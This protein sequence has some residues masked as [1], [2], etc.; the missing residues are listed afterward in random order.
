VASTPTTDLIVVQIPAGPIQTNA[1]LIIDPRS[2][3]ALIIDAP[4]E[5]ADAIEAELAS[6]NAMPTTL[7]ITHGHWDHI[8][9]ADEISRR[10]DIPLVVH[11]SERQTLETP[12]S[13]PVQIQPAQVSRT[14]DEGDMISVGDHA[15]EVLV[16]PGHSPGQI[17]LYSAADHLLFGGDTLFPNGYGRTDIPGASEV[18]TVETMRR[19]LTLP[20]DVTVLPGH[21]DATTIGR[22]RYWMKHVADTGQLLG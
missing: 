10:F 5:S 18:A 17:S 21:G 11:E 22:E 16:T 12:R 14:V 7:V 2:S 19:L 3:E 6:R 8:G 15:F 4:P 1:F 20:D 13:E 9:D